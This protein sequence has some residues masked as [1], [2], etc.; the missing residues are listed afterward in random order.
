M[1]DEKDP[2]EWFCSAI[3]VTKT[4]VLTSDHCMWMPKPAYRV[5]DEEG[6]R[7]KMKL[8]STE[9]ITWGPL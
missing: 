5:F 9:K 1:N 2:Y 8:V 6:E 3:L 7:N 4:K